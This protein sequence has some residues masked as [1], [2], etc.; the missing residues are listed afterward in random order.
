MRKAFWVLLL[1]A[2][3]FIVAVF[4]LSLV[5]RANRAKM[6]A[7][8]PL[9]IENIERM[10]AQTSRPEPPAN[11]E[12]AVTASPFEQ[13]GTLTLRRAVTREEAL[14]RLGAAHTKRRVMAHALMTVA[15]ALATACGLA[16][17]PA[18][19]GGWYWEAG[20]EAET[21]RDIDRART[22]YC[23][24]L[25]DVTEDAMR[26]WCL[27]RLAWYEEDPKVASALLNA[28]CATNNPINLMQA[29]RLAHLTGSTE[30]CVH[31]LEQL[32][33]IHPDSAEM[34]GME[35]GIAITQPE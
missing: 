4:A 27:A 1:I 16:G 13:S 35:L 11:G 32:R 21:L 7:A 26:D 17:I 3:C 33:T 24:A 30:A 19:R 8:P 29:V 5:S 28:S 31:Y 18:E 2:G 10:V 22:Y 15:D 6:I 20:Q 34:L 12:P 14:E 9:T 25:N 23:E